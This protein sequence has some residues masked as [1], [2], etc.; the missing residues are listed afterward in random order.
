[1][2]IGTLK[3]PWPRYGIRTG[4]YEGN[5][6]SVTKT[7]PLDTGLFTMYHAYKAGTTKFRQLFESVDLP[8]YETIRRTFQLVDSD[9]WTSA[10]LYW[11]LRHNLLTTTNEDGVFDIENT[12]HNI[13]FE[14]VKPMQEYQINSECSCVVCPKRRRQKTSVDISLS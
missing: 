8:V 9:G 2:T 4:I 5:I 11:L 14:F 3:L 10:R 1:M 7:C 6:Y 13:V 12:L